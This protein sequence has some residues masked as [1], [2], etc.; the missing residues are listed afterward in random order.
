MSDVLSDGLWRMF[1]TRAK[2]IYDGPGDPARKSAAIGKLAK[3][4]FVGGAAIANGSDAD[5]EG[6]DPLAD[7]A[8]GAVA[9]TMESMRSTAGASDRRGVFARAFDLLAGRGNRAS[10][11]AIRHGNAVCDSSMRRQAH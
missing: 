8:A 9:D 10:A 1:I 5:V 2:E 6:S 7:A 4:I 3:V 11:P